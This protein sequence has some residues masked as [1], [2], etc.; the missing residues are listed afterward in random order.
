M[1]RQVGARFT[2]AHA[3]AASRSR[4][5]RRRGLEALADELLAPGPERLRVLGIERIG[6]HATGYN[7]DR[8]VGDQRG[9]MAILA[10]APA[11]LVRRRHH[12]RPHAGRRTLRNVLVAVWR[13]S[14]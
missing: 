12:A 8:A 14:L 10:V 4:E 6:A 9:H 11:D 1:S 3:R 2:A 13:K 7:R 5:C